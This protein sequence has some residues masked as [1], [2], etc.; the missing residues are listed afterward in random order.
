MLWDYRLSSTLSLYLSIY[1]F[2]ITSLA[3]QSFNIDVQGFENVFY[4]LP[5]SRRHILATTDQY[6]RTGVM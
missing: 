1:I 4:N 3:S 6:L 2:K 5:H